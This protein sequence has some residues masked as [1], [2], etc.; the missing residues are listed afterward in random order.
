MNIQLI[1]RSA[2]ALSA[3]ALLAS[4]AS[5][6]GLAPRTQ[7]KDLDT[8]LA[9]EASLSQFI[10]S[11][12]QFPKSDWWTALGDPQLNSLISKALSSNPSLDAANARIDM[13]LAQVSLSDENGRLQGS[14]VAQASGIQLPESMIPAPIGGSFKTSAI[15][16]VNLS[17][18]FDLW[19]ADKAKRAAALGQYHA[20]E[21]D[22]Q[23]A[24]L[25][26]ASNIAKAYVTLDQ[27]YDLRDVAMREKKR[28]EGLVS[29]GGARVKKGLD[30]ELQVRNA[31]VALASAEQTIFAANQQIEVLRHAI[32]ALMGQ[33]PDQ[34]L[35]IQRPTLGTAG[36]L[37]I[38]SVLP[39]E[40]LGHRPDIVAARW[41]V[42]AA[43]RGIDVSKAA[44]Y[45]TINLS[46]MAGLAATNI[47]DLFS[48]KALLLQVGPSVTLPLFAQGRLQNQLE[49]S[50]AQYDLAVAQ[51][52]GT[53]AGALREVADA[54][55]NAK[56]LD[57]QI[58]ALQ[59]ASSAGNKAYQI[60]MARYKAG[61]GTQL[62]VLNAQR[63]LLQLDQQLATLRAQ[64]IQTVVDLNTALGGGVQL[65]GTQ[66]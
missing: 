45:P 25:S 54:L 9:T 41:R 18:N 34:G 16:R 15:A 60:A 46:G 35:Q 38:P 51:Y 29:L 61:L 1:R 28:N 21:V 19:G 30:N 17:K 48:T 14:A 39:S 10:K 4:C 42:E 49:I 13:A 40:L 66:Q 22:L 47:S 3:A 26:L 55:T 23:S 65:P 59:M 12:A 43:A 27:V 7:P 62:D 53:L 20:A 31:Q 37:G 58:S 24:R 2:L 52:N 63:P 64:R 6:G 32:A 8:T 44:F 50:N 5:T 36:K 33:G 56:N 11:D 57:A